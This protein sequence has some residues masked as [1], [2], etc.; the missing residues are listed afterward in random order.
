[1]DLFFTNNNVF[2]FN[3][4]VVNSSY[5]EAVNKHKIK[6]ARGELENTSQYTLKILY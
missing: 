2:N 1:M 5:N 4:E 6:V 3:R